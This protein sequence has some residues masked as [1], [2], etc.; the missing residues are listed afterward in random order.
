MSLAFLYRNPRQDTLVNIEFD[1]KFKRRE[2]SG[3]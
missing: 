1:L 2:L 3:T